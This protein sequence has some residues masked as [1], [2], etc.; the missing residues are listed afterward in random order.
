LA[1]F[2]DPPAVLRQLRASIDD[3]QKS[4]DL[5]ALSPAM[6]F[7]AFF[8]DPDLALH[9]A[10]KIAR[11]HVSFETWAFLIGRPVMTEVRRQ[12]GFQSLLQEIGLLDY[13]RSSG[14]WGDFCKPGVDRDTV[15][16]T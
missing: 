9:A 15:R 11:L 12:P 3:P 1:H 14:D 10:H 13:W 6:Q 16:C 7:A 2:D 8:G 5:F 4:S